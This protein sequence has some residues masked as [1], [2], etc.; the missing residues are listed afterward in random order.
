VERLKLAVRYY[1]VF[2]RHPIHAGGK[3]DDLEV[4]SVNP[5]PSPILFTGC[6][7]RRLTTNMH[8]L[9]FLPAIGLIVTAT[10]A[11]L[12]RQDNPYVGYLLSTFTDAD[13]RVFW[14][15]STA[16]SPLAFTPLNGGEPVLG[17]NVGT[18]A[19]RDIF[20][21]SND[22]RSEYFVI[23]TG[24]S[25]NPSDHNWKSSVGVAKINNP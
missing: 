4:I 22:D 19:V 9:P 5:Y 8:F 6:R 20:L 10:A 16:E 12:P 1:Y 13:P 25:F 18:Q 3:P 2:S 23:A 15:L 24:M 17:S 21:T 7:Q 11:V 14:Y